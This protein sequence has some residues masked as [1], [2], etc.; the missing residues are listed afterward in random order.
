MLPDAE[1]ATPLAFMSGAHA[2]QSHQAG[3]KNAARA[4]VTLEI[5]VLLALVRCYVRR[6]LK[7]SLSI[8]PCN[9]QGEL[10]HRWERKRYVNE[11]ASDHHWR[12][13]LNECEYCDDHV[14]KEHGL[15]CVW[16]YVCLRPAPRIRWP[17]TA[18]DFER[19]IFVP[20]CFLPRDFQ[21]S[22]GA[23]MFVPGRGRHELWAVGVA[24]G[25]EPS[26]GAWRVSMPP[27]SGGQSSGSALQASIT[28]VDCQMALG[29]LSLCS[30]PWLALW[31]CCRL[32]RAMRVSGHPTPGSGCLS[33]S[34]ASV[35]ALT[36]CLS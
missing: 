21:M 33:S 5:R 7:P 28:E 10:Q 17:K 8:N 18:T 34:C 14:R 24:A 4:E 27:G 11:V 1:S 2:L 23:H 22:P 32:R 25:S 16:S 12:V 29:A 31:R 9:E 26:G 3:Y 15:A 20:S 36:S 30:R 19:G 6:A 13:I 35:Q